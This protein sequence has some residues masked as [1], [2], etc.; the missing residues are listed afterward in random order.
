MLTVLK[1]NRASYIKTTEQIVTVSEPHV[2]TPHTLAGPI[3]SLPHTAS[4]CPHSRQSAARKHFMI[5][6]TC[7]IC[8]N[9]STVLLYELLMERPLKAQE[10]QVG[11]VGSSILLR[12]WWY[13]EAFMGTGSGGG[14]CG[15]GWG[16]RRCWICSIPLWAV[17]G[18]ASSS[19]GGPLGVE[20]LDL[21]Y[22]FTS[23]W[24]SGH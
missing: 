13:G 20:V 8:I 18:K 9:A 24:W 23:C 7:R 1:N 12:R 22:C 2:T 10:V 4:S 5:E 19:V 16:G 15:G 21:Q 11:G 14:S 17:D 6:I 3:P